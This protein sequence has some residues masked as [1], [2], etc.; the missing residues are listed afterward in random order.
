M[1]EFSIT[2][3]SEKVKKS[4]KPVTFFPPADAPHPYPSPRRRE[5]NAVRDSPPIRRS[6]S[7]R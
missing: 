3:L 2:F 7:P 1:H 6:P 4:K 5:G